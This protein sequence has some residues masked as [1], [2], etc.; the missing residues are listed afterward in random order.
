MSAVI[1]ARL[2]ALESRMAAI[3]ARLLAIVGDTTNV[4]S[5]PSGAVASDDDL[6]SEWGNPIVKKDPKKWVDDGGESYAGCRMSECPPKYLYML[7]SLFDWMAGKDEE[8]N[9]TYTSKQGKEVPTAPLNRKSAARARG[10]A[11]RNENRV[12]APV[13]QQQI[14]AGSV[15]FDDIP[16]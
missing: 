8:S 15:G 13:A 10:W 5:T 2:A 4:K 16:F 7:A 12:A 1:D 14:P 11:K 9:K 3:E 6:D